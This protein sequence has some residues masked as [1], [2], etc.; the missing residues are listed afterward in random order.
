M[1]EVINLNKSFNGKQVLFDVSAKF[2]RGKV[3]LIIGQSGSGKT[4]LVKS[5]VGLH[6]PELGEVLFDNDNVTDYSLSE[7]NKLRQN[8][9][10]LFQGGALFDSLTVQEN[11][12]F[13][14]SMFKDISEDEMKERANECL[15]QVNLVGVNHLYPSETSGGMQK[16]IAL[17]RAI[18]MNPKYLFVDEPNSGLDPITANVIDKL[19]K[20][21]TYKY[22]MTTIV[23]THDMN[24]VLEIG[25]N[26]LFIHDGRA[27]WTGTKDN[28]L[29]SDDA[30]LNKFVYA[31]EFIS[32][33]KE[34]FNQ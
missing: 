33:L 25:D 7:M 4:V 26:I 1:I 20:K 16:R 18:S 24:S 14:L 19:I 5:I 30:I 31:S 28:I 8:I 2:E 12:M 10:M 11:V 9:G 13:P 17:A 23:V 21:L 29:K 6:H 3:N 27:H 32:A 22:N 34:G 15:D